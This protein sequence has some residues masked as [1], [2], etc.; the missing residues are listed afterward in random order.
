MKTGR[1]IRNNMSKEQLEKKRKELTESPIFKQAQKTL[2]NLNAHIQK[3]VKPVLDR[4]AQAHKQ[5]NTPY[6]GDT[7]ISIPV[8]RRDTTQQEILKELKIL[9][10]KKLAQKQ[11]IGS[12]IVITYDAHEGALTRTIDGKPYS[13]SFTGNAKRKKLFELFRQKK[14]YMQL[15]EL[16]VLLTSPTTDSV[17]TMIKTLNEKVDQK[18]HL[19]K[20]KIIIAKPGSGYRINP[21][22]IIER[23]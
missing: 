10:Q 18:L 12:E 3:N 22:V 7:P 11:P 16:K 15:K 14:S 17:S 6:F 4:M 2:D 20:L 19:S 21:R 5:I 23:A 8:A 9:N 1:D 13:Y